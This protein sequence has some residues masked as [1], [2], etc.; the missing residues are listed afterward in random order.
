M[1][2]PPGHPY[3]LSLPPKESQMVFIYPQFCGKQRLNVIFQKLS[4]LPTFML[5]Q[6]FTKPTKKSQGRILRL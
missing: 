5:A 2:I 3:V 4:R 1:P 6:F